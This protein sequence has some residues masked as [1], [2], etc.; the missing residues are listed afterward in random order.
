MP[1]EKL[2][3]ALVLFRGFEGFERAEVPP[4]SGLRVLF[5]RVETIFT[6]LQFSNHVLIIFAR[7]K[8]VPKLRSSTP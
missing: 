8:R 1:F 4:F 5:P 7:K 6:G 3:R 2:N